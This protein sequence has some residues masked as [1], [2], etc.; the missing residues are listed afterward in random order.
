MQLAL[1]LI[2]LSHVMAVMNLLSDQ[3]LKWTRATVNPFGRGGQSERRT[4]WARPSR[5]PF[6]VSGLAVK[7]LSRGSRWLA[8]ED[9]NPHKQIQSRGP[10]IRARPMVSSIIM[11]RRGS[12]HRSIRP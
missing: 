4:R 11:C 5:S 9:S 6:D 10:A 7:R 8:G 3:G 2:P 12:R 1:P